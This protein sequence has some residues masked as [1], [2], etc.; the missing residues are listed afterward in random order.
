MFAR[1]L[2]TLTMLVALWTEIV[3][4]SSTAFVRTS[5]GPTISKLE[6][7]PNSAS[8]QTEK[9]DSSSHEK[10][11]SPVHLNSAT[12]AACP[13]SYIPF[14]IYFFPSTL[15]ENAPSFYEEPSLQ[16]QHRPPK[17]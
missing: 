5:V 17:A 8:S 9:S 7:T 10:S 4:D 1:T 2:I 14:S 6:V 15:H 11:S 13:V 3:I 16:L 12:H